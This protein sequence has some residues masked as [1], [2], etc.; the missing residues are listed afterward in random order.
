MRRAGPVLARAA[1]CGL[2]LLAGG[3]T[4]PRAGPTGG[5]IEDGAGPSGSAAGAPYVL[6]DLTT[7]IGQAVSDGAPPA[8]AS[9]GLPPGAPVGL[10]GPEDT[11]R[12]TLWEPNPTGATLLDRPG[13]DL[14]VRVGAD[15]TIS[16]PYVGRLRAAGRSPAAVEEAI[17][18]ELGN[19]GHVMQASAFVTDD[20][21]NT[22]VVQGDVMKPGRYPI[23]PGARGVL[24]V[25]AIAGGGKSPDHASI[26]RVSRRDAAVTASMTKLQ[27]SG[28]ANLLLS[29][30]DRVL[31]M[32]RVRYFYAFGAVA[33]PGQQAYDDEEMSMARTLGR[34]AGLDD[35]K[36]N[37]GGVFVYR[38]QSAELTR[39]IAGP[40]L[41]ADQD[42]T[43]VVYRIDLRDP[44]GFFVAEAFRIRPEDIV[45]VSN[46]PIAD[47][48]KVLQLING[49]AA[50]GAVPRN[51]GAQY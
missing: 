39:R 13:L 36:A 45:Y 17:R 4:I 41:R 14:T 46:A 35:L 2:A 48:I 16:V 7:A 42:P 32:Q 50:I 6:I 15:G 49:V 12:I 33:R 23:A 26:V 24:D 21:T 47:A 31:V 20:V 29:P 8:E 22:V 5:A 37:P 43:R 30:G 44:M 27:Q 25:V 38:R 9:G 34:I 1:C 18:T 11:L 51:Y 3:C 40:A 28:P 19:Q 10:L